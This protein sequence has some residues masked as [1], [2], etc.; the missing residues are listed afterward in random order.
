MDMKQ[1]KHV[2]KIVLSSGLSRSVGFI[3]IFSLSNNTSATV[4]KERY[5]MH[6]TDKQP[7]PRDGTSVKTA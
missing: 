2:K 1:I 5:K 3:Y 7:R 6:G 4:F